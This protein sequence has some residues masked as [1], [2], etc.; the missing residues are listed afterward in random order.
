MGS[1]SLGQLFQKSLTYEAGGGSDPAWLLPPRQPRPRPR[2]LYRLGAIGA[3]VFVAGAFLLVV[4]VAAPS[5]PASRGQAVTAG[6]AI[7]LGAV[8]LVA[9]WIGLLGS[10]HGGVLAIVACLGPPFAVIYFREHMHDRYYIE[11]T[12]AL[13]GLGFGGFAGG[14]MF[15]RGLHTGVRVTAGLALLFVFLAFAAEAQRWQISRGM[16]MT[17][18]LAAFGGLA[19]LGV[20]LAVN[21]AAIAHRRRASLRS[22]ASGTGD[23]QATVQRGI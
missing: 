2:W 20:T 5:N 8:V 13:V 12:T 19:A 10:G 3:G 14:H 22:T 17:L 23:S 16:L 9:A 18:Y 7:T 21:L 1:K 4:L 6:I 15:A 11:T